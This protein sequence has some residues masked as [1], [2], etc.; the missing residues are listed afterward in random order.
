MSQ[1][2]QQVIAASELPALGQPL[3]GGVFAARYWLNGQERA[4]ILLSDEFEG[5]WGEYGVEIAGASSYSDGHA[6]TLAMVEGGSEIAKKALEL[7]AYIPSCLEGQLLMAAK[8][9]GLVTLREDRWHWLSSQYSAH[10]AFSMDVEDGWL[11]DYG[12]DIVRLVRPVRSRI[13]Q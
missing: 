8:A 4:L 5:P 7:D 11:D 6:N 12:K 2:N 9:D 13:I 10:D 3:L 1:V